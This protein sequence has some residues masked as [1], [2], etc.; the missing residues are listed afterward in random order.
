LPHSGKLLAET[1]VKLFFPNFSPDY[2]QYE[3]DINY[4]AMSTGL[5]VPK[6]YQLL[7]LEGRQGII[8]ERIEGPLMLELMFTQAH[9][10]KK[11]ARTFAELHA[12]IHLTAV[13]GFPSVRTGLTDVIGAS[14]WINASEK[15]Q[16]LRLLREL[17]GGNVLIHG[18]FHPGNITLSA[19]GAMVMDW[20]TAKQA[21][22]HADIANT[23]MIMRWASV[24]GNNEEVIARINAVRGAFLHTYQQ[25]YMELQPDIR[26]EEVERWMIP[27][28]VGRL[29]LNNED[30]RENLLKELQG[31]LKKY[32]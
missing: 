2:V 29:A 28:I 15:E 14:A 16:I 20:L 27:I 6:V 21:N 23:V 24:P 30:E 8:F 11:L 25:R 1:R 10:V 4:K 18:D 17:P 32:P 26:W 12:Q 31:L 13:S 22:P 3:Y 5:P 19:R 7:E 9:E